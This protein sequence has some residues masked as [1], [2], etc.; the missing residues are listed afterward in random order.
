MGIESSNDKREWIKNNRLHLSANVGT[1]QWPA[2][3][4]SSQ[5]E[6][7]FP[8]T[9]SVSFEQRETVSFFPEHRRLDVEESGM[10]G[11]GMEEGLNGEKERKTRDIANV[12][13][14]S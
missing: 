8:W 5:S 3:P 7:R 13:K 2:P 6:G 9:R 11:S 10:G 14:A 1:N 12:A 4:P